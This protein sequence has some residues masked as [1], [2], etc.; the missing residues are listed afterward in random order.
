LTVCDGPSSLAASAALLENE[1]NDTAVATAKDDSNLIEVVIEASSFRLGGV[2]QSQE[3][4]A[5]AV[6]KLHANRYRGTSA[7]KNSTLPRERH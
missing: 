3:K 2:T 4:D 6:I 1:N 7:R 5:S